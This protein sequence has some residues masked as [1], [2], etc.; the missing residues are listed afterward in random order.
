MFGIS[1]STTVAIANGVCKAIA[2][3]LLKKYIT[4]QLGNRLDAVIEKL[5]QQDGFPQVGGAMDGTHIFVKAPAHI[6]MNTKT[7]NVSTLLSYQVLRIPFG[8]LLTSMYG[9]QEECMSF[10]QLLTIQKGTSAA[11]SFS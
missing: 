6:L 8:A 11:I 2:V 5:Q 4:I 10:L 3:H 9:S 1:Q 7:E